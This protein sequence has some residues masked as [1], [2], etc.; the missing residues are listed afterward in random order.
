M[1]DPDQR[2]GRWSTQDILGW[3]TLGALVVYGSVRFADSA[4]YSRLGTSPDAVG[5]DYAATLSRV[6]G[7]V[8]LF[9]ATVMLIAG[10][11]RLVEKEISFALLLLTLV[12][13]A[14]GVAVFGVLLPPSQHVH[15]FNWVALLLVI[16][17]FAVSTSFDSKPLKALRS[18]LHQ[19]RMRRIVAGALVVVAIF[20]LSGLSGYRS[21]GYLIEG[22]S[23]PCGCVRFMRW[24]MS[25]PWASGSE[26]FLGVDAPP[27][28]VRWVDAARTSPKFPENLFYLGSAGG[29][30]VFFDPV[31]GMIENIPADA[32]VVYASGHTVGFTE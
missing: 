30:D 16:S 20:G 15:G 26:G 22:K 25:L 1:A 6:A 28:K 4:F 12:V 9:L 17:I 10:L 24:N 18:S 3:L 21:A 13:G 27:V 11:G 32:V 5:L 19:S 8:V 2:P 29:V 14:I 31:A 23:L 7:V